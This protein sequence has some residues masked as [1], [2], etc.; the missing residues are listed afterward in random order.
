MTSGAN[1]YRWSTRSSRLSSPRPR[2]RWPITPAR[3]GSTPWSSAVRGTNSRTRPKGTRLAKEDGGPP[4]TSFACA[5]RA[6]AAR[7][8]R[9]PVVVR[10]SKED[11]RT[12][13]GTGGEAGVIRREEQDPTPSGGDHLVRSDLL[14]EIYENQTTSI[15]RARAPPESDRSWR[16]RNSDGLS[17]SSKE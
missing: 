2:S 16:W 12:L 10:T 14:D 15:M 5:C 9:R 4:P 8:A 3:A 13:F 17:Q 11:G 7:T 6:Q 1:P